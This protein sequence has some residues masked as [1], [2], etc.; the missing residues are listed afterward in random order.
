MPEKQELA[1][2]YPWTASDFVKGSPLKTAI[3]GQLMLVRPI[4]RVAAIYEHD[5]PATRRATGKADLR[6]YR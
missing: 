5:G 6:V 4:S 3:L 1:A 2:T